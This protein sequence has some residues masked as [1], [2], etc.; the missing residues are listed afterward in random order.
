M[1]KTI[2]RGFGG[3][4]LLSILF[5][6]GCIVSEAPLAEPE[7]A[8]D[9][10]ALI[11]SWESLG[12]PGDEVESTQF[13]FEKPPEGWPSRTL[14]VSSETRRTN[15]TIDRGQTIAYLVKVGDAEYLHLL[16]LSPEAFKELDYP[17]WRE[18]EIR[19]FQ[20]WSI[21]RTDHAFELFAADQ[22]KLSALIEAEVSGGLDK[23]QI[24]K[25]RERLRKEGPG[26]IFQD[27]VFMKFDQKQ[28]PSV[29]KSR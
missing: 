25:V 5:W 21:R 19:D 4:G 13:V 12:K 26:S 23:E 22:E 8:T 28:T 17:S 6:L 16:N 7:H 29:E 15:G 1:K 18:K 24:A 10:S 14:K 2:Q 11:G 27:Q 3:L 9:G 20:I